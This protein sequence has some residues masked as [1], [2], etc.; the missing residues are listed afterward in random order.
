VR[1]DMSE[2]MEKHAVS[3]LIGSPPGYVGHEE[4]GQLTERMRR[5]PYSLILFDEIEKAHPDVRNLLLQILEDGQLT[6]AY[7]NL[8][9]FKNTLV[10]MT[11]NIGS[12]LVLRGGRMGFG[13]GDRRRLSSTASKRRSWPSCGGPSRPSSSTASTR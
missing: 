13:E 3:K 9:D 2:Y 10:L 5:Q 6:D 4:G 12:K 7:G 8:V 11:S 1:F